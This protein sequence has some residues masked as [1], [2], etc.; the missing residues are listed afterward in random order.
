LW[1]APNDLDADK[2]REMIADLNLKKRLG[3]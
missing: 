3:K 1:L 2:V